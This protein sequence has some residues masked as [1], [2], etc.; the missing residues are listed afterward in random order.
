MALQFREEKDFA[1]FLGVHIKGKRDRLIYLTQK[2]L[3][4]R[5]EAMNPL[6]WK[7][8]P[9]KCALVKERETQ[10]RSQL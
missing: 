10:S 9:Q 3:A 8:K 7:K 5:K 6:K 1:G 2:V 4:E